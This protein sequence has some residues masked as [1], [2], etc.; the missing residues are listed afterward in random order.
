[1]EYLEPTR[2]NVDTQ[3]FEPSLRGPL[4]ELRSGVKLNLNLMVSLNTVGRSITMANG[5]VES[6]VSPIALRLAEQ[7]FESQQPM[8]PATQ[9]SGLF[10]FPQTEVNQWAGSN[11]S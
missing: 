7:F 11:W 4:L 3:T 1:M 6:N 5:S 2:T 9:A 10:D 8:E